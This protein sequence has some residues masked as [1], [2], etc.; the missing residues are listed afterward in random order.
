MIVGDV[1][2]R[3]MSSGNVLQITLPGGTRLATKTVEEAQLVEPM[4]TKIFTRGND[5]VAAVILYG[6]GVWH[7]CMVL[8]Y[9]TAVWYC[10]MVL[11]YGTAEGYCCMALL[12]GSASRW[13]LGTV[14][15]SHP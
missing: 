15:N 14:D 8:L 7:F 1:L 6:T 12:Y 2:G 11:L 10:R 13:S 9:G 4:Y 3:S 5:T